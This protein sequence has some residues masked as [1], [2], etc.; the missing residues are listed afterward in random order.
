MRQSLVMR[1]IIANI[2]FYLLL[3]GAMV[4]VDA[5]LH[6]M[7]AAWMGRYLGIPGT[8]LILFSFLHSARKRKYIKHGSPKT[9]L[10]L[11][12]LLGWI[13]ALLVLVHAGFHF[14]AWLPWAALVAMLIVIAS[15]FVGSSLLKSARSELKAQQTKL[16]QQEVS[17]EEIQAQLYLD[18]YAVDVMQ[19]WRS[20]HM[21][22]TGIFAVLASIHILVFVLFW[23]W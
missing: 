11:H 10:Q 9:Y 5:I 14:N 6:W 21:P 7:N 20:I 18:S 15:G 8:L 19:K 2:A 12:E 3:I 17:E 16:R 22:L 23:R 13:G 4:V 1:D